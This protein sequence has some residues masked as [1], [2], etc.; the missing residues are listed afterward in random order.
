MIFHST[1]N[2]KNELVR[3]KGGDGTYIQVSPDK[4]ETMGNT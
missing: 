3:R 4:K 1:Q 2:L